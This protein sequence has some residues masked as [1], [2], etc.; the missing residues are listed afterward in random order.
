ML[1]W[2]IAV[3]WVTGAGSTIKLRPSIS[4]FLSAVAPDSMLAVKGKHVLCT[5][6]CAF[7]LQLVPSA[8]ILHHSYDLIDY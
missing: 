5:P 2:L 1:T 7:I 4:S 8:V 3:S 6:Y